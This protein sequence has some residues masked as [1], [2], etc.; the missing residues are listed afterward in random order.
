VITHDLTRR[1]QQI[2][3][4]IRATAERRGYT[5]TVRE[6]REAVGLVSP[7]SVAYHIGVLMRKGYLPW[8][9]ED[10]PPTSG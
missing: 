8:T 5:P 4:F 10:P 7:S 1:Q 3:D 6:I 9:N 2:L